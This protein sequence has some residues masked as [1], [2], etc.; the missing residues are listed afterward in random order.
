MSH[1]DTIQ[2]MYAAFVRGDVPAILA[3]LDDDV[4]W[5]YGIKSTDVPWLEPRRGRAAV[6]GFFESLAA[7]IEWH[8]F[9]P[10]T[11]FEQGT[12]VVV[13]LDGE[14]TVKTTGRRVL[15][16]DGIHIWHLNGAGKVVRFC[17][18]VDTYQ[19]WVAWSGTGQPLIESAS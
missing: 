15:Q 18:R 2:Q 19:Y 6:T 3:H 11:F 1:L 14:F 10:K 7:L 17:H 13:L 5:E 8:R 4:V 12:T 9:E 16:E